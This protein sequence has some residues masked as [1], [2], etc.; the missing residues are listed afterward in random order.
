MVAIELIGNIL[1]NRHIA[2]RWIHCA[3]RSIPTIYFLIDD[4]RLA[5]VNEYKGKICVFELSQFIVS[6]STALFR[7]VGIEIFFSLWKYD[8]YCEI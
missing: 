3:I 4:I 8:T 1:S 6:G 5:T 7:D 2:I